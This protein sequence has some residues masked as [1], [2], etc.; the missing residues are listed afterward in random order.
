[1]VRVWI[2]DLE[3]SE[4]LFV[5][6]LHFSGL[7]CLGDTIMMKTVQCLEPNTLIFKLHGH[8]FIASDSFI[9]GMSIPRIRFH[10]LPLN[11][12][13]TRK[14]SYAKTS[15]AKMQRTLRA[16][17]QIN[18]GNER[19]KSDILSRGLDPA[20]S[21]H[22]VPVQTTS[23]RQQIFSKQFKQ[24]AT[25]KKEIVLQKKIETLKLKLHLLHQERDSIIDSI[26]RKKEKFEDTISET[27]KSIDEM[28]EKFHSLCKDKEK[29]AD[30]LNTFDEFRSY[31][32][33]TRSDLVIRRKQLISQLVEIFPIKDA[34]T[35]HP[36]IGMSFI[37]KQR[38]KCVP[39]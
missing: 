21:D 15:L 5:L 1:M 6:G 19:L 16:L 3:K 31:N 4:T 38:I 39:I 9:N 23:L 24:P 34:K 8:F 10:E 37:R 30:W 22:P 26:E 14:P 25:K 12:N 32:A 35:S 18:I 27:D 20:C 17:K 28:T 36:T 33:A 7:V 2:R 11:H 13:F 29:L